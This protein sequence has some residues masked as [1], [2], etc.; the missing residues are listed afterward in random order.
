MGLST[1]LYGIHIS[2]LYALTALY[3]NVTKNYVFWYWEKLRHRWGEGVPK[4]LP[5][6]RNLRVIPTRWNSADLFLFEYVSL[7]FMQ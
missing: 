4:K 1:R 6:Q 2:I 5:V 7:N 3:K